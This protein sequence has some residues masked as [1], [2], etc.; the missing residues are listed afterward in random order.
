MGGWSKVFLLTLVLTA[1]LQAQQ[2][3]ASVAIQDGELLVA[4]PLSGRSPATIYRYTRSGDGWEQVGTMTAPTTDQGGDYFGRFIASDD[5]TMFIGGTLYENSTG[6]VWIYRREGD[7]WEFDEVLQPEVLS[8]EEAFGRFGQLYGDRL[9]VSSLGFRGVGGVWVFDRDPSGQ[10]VESAL[11]QPE[12]P[13][14]Q[15]FFGWSLAYDGERLIVGSFGGDEGR[16]AA[17]VFVPDGSGGWLQ[18][19]RLALGDDESQPGDVGIPG[20]G[21]AGSP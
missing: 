4:E 11:L 6:A 10:W 5:R 9:F 15:E 16:G 13:A 2:F 12:A 1:P 19:A 14:P 21:G 17:Y 8:E 18:E 7:Q 20:S 3:G